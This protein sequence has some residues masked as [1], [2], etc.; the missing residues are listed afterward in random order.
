MKLGD[1]RPAGHARAGTSSVTLLQ[2]VGGTVGLAIAGTIFGSTLLDEVPRQLVAAGVPPEFANQFTSGGGAETFND[3]TS[4][5]DLGASILAGVPEQFRATVEPMIPAIVDGI[6]A[7]FSIATG[8]TFV[9][10]IVTALLAAF[11]LLVLM[12]AGRVGEREE[13]AAR[14]LEPALE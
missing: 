5:G 3:L 14:T 11:L 7:A 2:Q 12:P 1:R 13:T 8:A 4:V 9:V 10:G 6:H